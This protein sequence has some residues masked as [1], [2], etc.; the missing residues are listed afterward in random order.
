MSS[1]L[2][3]ENSACLLEV[4]LVTMEWFLT[5]IQIVELFSSP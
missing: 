4:C 3:M 1:R 5:L 2:C